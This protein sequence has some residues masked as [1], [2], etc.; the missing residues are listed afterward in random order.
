[1][2]CFPPSQVRVINLVILDFFHII[3]SGTLPIHHLDLFIN[4]IYLWQVKNLLKILMS[5]SIE[6]RRWL[7]YVG[8]LSHLLGIGASVFRLNVSYNLVLVHGAD[9]NSLARAN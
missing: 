2:L 6:C 3:H 9:D 1:M 8:S 5:V 4:V 7:F